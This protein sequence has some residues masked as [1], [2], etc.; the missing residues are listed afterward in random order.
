MPHSNNNKKTSA[1]AKQTEKERITIVVPLKTQNEKIEKLTQQNS[2]YEK[3]ITDTSEQCSELQK[4]LKDALEKLEQTESQLSKTKKRFSQSKKKLQQTEKKLE[5][6]EKILKQTHFELINVKDE[7]EEAQPYQCCTCEV[8]GHSMEL[9]FVNCF[10]C[11]R[12]FC[13]DLF[14]EDRPCGHFITEQNFQKELCVCNEC[15]S[16]N[17][18]Y[19]QRTSSYKSTAHKVLDY[20]KLIKDEAHVSAE[21]NPVLHGMIAFHY[22]MQF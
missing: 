19:Y 1:A 3:Q 13:M 6:T 9:R 2:V 14:D 7:L 4:M 11:E 22:D 16:P 21:K 12:V 5:Q 18:E 8:R 20:Q 15:F 17:Q 10:H